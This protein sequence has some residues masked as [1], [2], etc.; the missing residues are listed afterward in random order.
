MEETGSSIL[1]WLI[2][3]GVAALLA[4]GFWI[5]DRM[6]NPS[7]KQRSKHWQADVDRSKAE[8]LRNHGPG[9]MDR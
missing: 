4:A 2:G 5:N 7:H 8:T 9:G 3:I 1:I 6:T